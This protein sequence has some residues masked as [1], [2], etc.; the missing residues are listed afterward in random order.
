MPGWNTEQIL[1][2]IQLSL[3]DFDSGLVDGRPDDPVLRQAE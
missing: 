3:V 2:F 1:D